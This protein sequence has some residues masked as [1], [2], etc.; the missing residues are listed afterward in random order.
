MNLNNIQ[1][2]FL[3]VGFI[4]SLLLLIFIE[5]KTIYNFF[6]GIKSSIQSQSNHAAT[7]NEDFGP[8]TKQEKRTDQSVCRGE[9]ELVLRSLGMT[10][11]SEEEKLPARLDFDQLFNLFEEE[12]PTFN[13]VK[14]A[15]DVFDKNGDGF[16]DAGELQN[17][18]C[19]LGFKEG[20]EKENCWRMIGVFDENDDGRIDFDEFLKIMETSSC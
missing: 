18:L 12:H 17:V 2:T 8:S 14:E 6:L 7:K 19:A 16:I 4:E 11:N 5:R 15:F 13:E 20:S 3:I 9:M 1:L 10:N